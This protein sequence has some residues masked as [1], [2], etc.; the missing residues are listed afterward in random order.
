M[1]LGTLFEANQNYF[2]IK[3]STEK[4]KIE[5]NHNHFW[6][7]TSTEKTNCEASQNHYRAKIKPFL[8]HTKTI[9]ELGKNNKQTKKKQFSYLLKWS[10]GAAADIHPDP[11]FGA[12]GTLLDMFLDGFKQQKRKKKQR[13]GIEKMR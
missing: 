4:Q 7:K 8:K 13:K 1:K 11:F 2:W 10:L 9:F 3:T 5:A 6:V 12:P